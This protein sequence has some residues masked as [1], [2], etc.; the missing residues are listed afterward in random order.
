MS[1][2][3]LDFIAIRGR[4]YPPMGR[5]EKLTAPQK[6]ERLD[7]HE[8]LLLVL[9]ML[10][11][12]RLWNGQRQY[13]DAIQHQLVMS[14]SHCEISEEAWDAL[15]SIIDQHLGDGRAPLLRV[16]REGLQER[17]I[18]L[19]LNPLP[20]TEWERGFLSDMHWKLEN[21]TS[22]TARQ[23]GVITKLE[24]RVKA[25]VSTLSAPSLPDDGS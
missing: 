4:T 5:W 21:C 3:P 12:Y 23:Y 13:L 8:D 24:A 6:A 15:G 19:L 7:V 14:G 2:Q 17:V 18:A 16:G 25:I 20:L 10:L 11:S 22:L 1:S 9:Q